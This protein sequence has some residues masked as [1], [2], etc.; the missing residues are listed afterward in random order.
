[1]KEEPFIEDP[2]PAVDLQFVMNGPIFDEGLPLPLT[3]K[4]LE[5]IQGIAD[6]S[7]LVLANKR[8]M[9]AQERNLFYL[10]SQ[11]IQRGSLIAAM[12]LVF[13]A[14]QPALPIVSNH[15]PTGV[16]EYAKHSF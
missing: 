14:V 16:W 12:G 5:A 4:S 15:G 3:I 2:H 6:K 8:R 7:Y 11:G 13:T 10:Q 9:S 1:M